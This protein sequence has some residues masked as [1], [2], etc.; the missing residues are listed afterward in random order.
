MLPQD[1]TDRMKDIMGAEY[2]AFEQS[3]EHAKYQAL[4]INPLKVEKQVFLEQAP[5]TLEQ[6]PWCENGYYYIADDTPGK[7]PYHEAG[8]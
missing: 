7:H 4:R 8:V 1:F 5:F 6:V 2:E 3:Y